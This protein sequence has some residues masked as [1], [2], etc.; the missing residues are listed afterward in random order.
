MI[1]RYIR[2]FGQVQGVGFRYKCHYLARE[3]GITGWISN[4]FDGSVEG[5]FQ[6]ARDDIDA[7]VYRLDNDIYISIEKMERKEIPLE[8]S[9]YN[10][11]IR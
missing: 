4:L 7:L 10:F 1:R 3:Y 2:F 6:G 5:E 11:E 9:E 8:E